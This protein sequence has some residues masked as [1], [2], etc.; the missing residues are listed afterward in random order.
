VASV[1]RRRSRDS[2]PAAFFSKQQREQRVQIDFMG[3]QIDSLE[4]IGCDP[5]TEITPRLR[6]MSGRASW[7]S[8][9]AS[10]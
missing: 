9:P 3:L 6:S 10:S 7:L 8:V 5:E 2:S 4:L 1:D